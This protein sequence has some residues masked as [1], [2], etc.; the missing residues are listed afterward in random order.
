MQLIVLIAILIV[1]YIFFNGIGLFERFGVSRKTDL[2]SKIYN[3]YMSFIETELQKNPILMQT[4]NF[5]IVLDAVLHGN[6]EL[7]EFRNLKGLSYSNEE[8]K[9]ALLDV[10]K[11]S[12]KD[13]EKAGLINALSVL[14]KPIERY[15]QRMMDFHITREY[16]KCME[17]DNKFGSDIKDASKLPF[18]REVILESLC[19]LY[20]E[21]DNAE[22][23]VAKTGILML[24]DYQ[25]D[26]GEDLWPDGFDILKDVSEW[27]DDLTE[28]QQELIT[29]KALQN[30]KENESGFE[31]K[32][33]KWELF[34][35]LRKRD[36]KIFFEKIDADLP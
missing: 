5:K 22:R 21:K 7:L 20:S 10:L 8:I 16:G 11:R 29:Q 13:E 24:A 6:F 30:F 25:E 9:K 18:P 12:E 34:D 33:K 36:I 27:N 3:E 4:D 1:A 32:R 19:R 28:E 35:K 17:R 2:S 31:E 14:H 26:V 23:G 15:E